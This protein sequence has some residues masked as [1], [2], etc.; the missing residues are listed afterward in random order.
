MR[1]R[2]SSTSC[3]PF[4]PYLAPYGPG[5][6][7]V[8]RVVGNEPVHVPAVELPTDPTFD[9]VSPAEPTASEDGVIE[10][11]FAAPVEAEVHGVEDR[12]AVAAVDEDVADAG[13][14]AG[15]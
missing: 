10:P 2:R 9:I 5:R 8:R 13:V 4:I 12:P 15:E 6:Q 14:D 3:P 11:A 1:L 7:R